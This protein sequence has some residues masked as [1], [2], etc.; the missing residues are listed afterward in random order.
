MRYPLSLYR[1]W[2]S[3]STWP[4]IVVTSLLILTSILACG[5]LLVL[6]GLE[7]QDIAGSVAF[8]NSPYSLILWFVVFAPIF[9]TMIGQQ[10]P[11]YLSYRWGGKYKKEIAT[12]SSVIL[13]SLLRFHYSIWSSISAV[14]AGFLLVESFIIFKKRKESAFWVT[15]AIHFLKNAIAVTYLILDK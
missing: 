5:F 12:I 6:F 11:V 9:E 10:L 4:F 13:F 3:L 2:S 14:P 8:D 7:I 1:K 15:T